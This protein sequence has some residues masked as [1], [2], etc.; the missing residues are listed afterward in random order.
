VKQCQNCSRPM[1]RDFIW[2]WMENGAMGDHSWLKNK[3]ESF[4]GR[5]HLPDAALL[6]GLPQA[7]V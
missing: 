7:V 2:Q 6:P 5:R 4:L 3:L 1:N